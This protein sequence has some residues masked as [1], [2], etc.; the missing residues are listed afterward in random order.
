[1][2]ARQR[3]LLSALVEARAELILDT[4]VAELSCVGRFSGAAKTAPWANP[5]AV[6]TADDLSPTA[7]RDVLGQIARFAVEQGFH[8][9]QAPTHLLVDAADSMFSVDLTSVSGLRTA[10]DQNGGRHIGID[11]PL[12]IPNG[13]L[14]DAAQLAKLIDGLASVHF[15]NLWLRVSGFGADASAAG[16]RR[17]IQALNRFHRLQRP[18]VADEVG[19]LAGLA[20]VAFG[21]AGGICHGAAEKERFSAAGWNSPNVGGGGGHEKRVLVEGL[22]RLL[23]VQQIHILMASP[24]AR[25]HFSCGDPSCCPRGLDDTLKDPK[26]HYLRQRQAQVDELTRVPDL[27][28]TKHFLD[29]RLAPV[30]AGAEQAA[31]LNV[32][33]ERLSK[34]LVSNSMRLERTQKVLKTLNQALSGEDRSAQ[35]ICRERSAGTRARDIGR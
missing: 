9:V 1:M 17:Y 26:A 28:R 29:K 7:Q 32:S 4:N 5:G 20:T 10:L 2:V 8:A 24:G 21:A 3:D 34:M 14:R 6:L 16:L 30:R 22:D 11:Y 35:T 13:L 31:K 23:S 15:D 25:R 27:R 18:I 33:D 19:G 12:I